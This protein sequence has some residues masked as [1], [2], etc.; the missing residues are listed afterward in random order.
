[1]LTL[2]RALN[3]GAE[4][5]LGDM[6]T[7]L[8]RRTFD[9]VFVDDLAVMYMATQD[10]LRSCMETAFAHTRPGGSGAVR[11][12][13]HAGDLRARHRSRRPRRRRR[14]RAPLPRV[15]ARARGRASSSFAVDYVFVLLTEPGA[16]ARVV[17]DRHLHG[18]FAEHTWL[19]LL[20]AAGFAAHVDPGNP[21]LKD[22]AQPV[23]GGRRPPSKLT[24]C[25]KVSCGLTAARV[26]STSREIC[27]TERLLGA[28][29]RLVAEPFP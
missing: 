10:D 26:A 8:V 7:L 3:P 25:H 13:L 27:A 15:D 14:A 12:R 28:E 21:E 24:K 23:F 22:E 1:M 9:A 2:S 16:D 18:L 5:V 20:E 6:R 17:H 29:H 4:H 11:A 19:Y